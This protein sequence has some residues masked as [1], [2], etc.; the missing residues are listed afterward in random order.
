[1]HVGRIKVA[2]GRSVVPDVDRH[3][4]WLRLRSDKADDPLRTGAEL[5]TRVSRRRVE[6]AAAGLVEAI[7]WDEARPL[8]LQH[9]EDDSF[10]VILRRHDGRLLAGHVG[11]EMVARLRIEEAINRFDVGIANELKTNLSV[12]RYD[13]HHHGENDKKRYST[14]GPPPSLF[15]REIRG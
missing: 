10:I 12:R 3:K 2:I 15:L 13:D 6:V 9:V 1:A 8:A 7:H 4:P 14:H 11:V 5:L